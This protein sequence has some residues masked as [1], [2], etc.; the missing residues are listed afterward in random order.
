MLQ[1]WILHAHARISTKAKHGL[2]VFTKQRSEHVK[3]HLP[4]RSNDCFCPWSAQWHVLGE[5]RIRYYVVSPAFRIFFLPRPAGTF[6]HEV[7][8]RLPLANCSTVRASS[9]SHLVQ[10]HLAGR[11]S[12]KLPTGTTTRIWKKKMFR[13]LRRVT[14]WANIALTS[15]LS[16]SSSNNT[17]VTSLVRSSCLWSPALIAQNYS[18]H[19]V[20]CSTSFG[21]TGSLIDVRLYR[22]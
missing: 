1:L 12:F 10:S 9:V 21:M 11:P 7:G 8:A 17:P 4:L 15:T 20:S 5:K 16:M 18:V 6:V 3:T 19:G 2:F 22:P 13:C 14:D